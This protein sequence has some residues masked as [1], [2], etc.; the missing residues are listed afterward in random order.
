[1]NRWHYLASIARERT[2]KRADE[3]ARQRTL[4]G[5]IRG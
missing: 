5:H 3:R 1:M 2:G 4:D